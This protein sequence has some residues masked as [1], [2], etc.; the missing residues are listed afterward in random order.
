MIDFYQ[1]LESLD[2]YDIL[3][4]VEYRKPQFKTFNLVLSTLARIIEQK[5]RVFF[6]GDYDVDGLMCALILSEG[7]KHLGLEHYDIFKYRSRTHSLDRGAVHECLQGNYDCFIIGDTGFSASDVESLKMLSRAGI[8]VV[9]LDHHETSFSY[10]DLPD[11]VIG[12]NTT[13]ETESAPDAS[14][15]S[16]GALCFVVM[17]ALAGYMGKKFYEPLSAYATISLYADCMDMRSTLNRAI[18][19]RARKVSREDLPRKVKMFMNSYSSFNSRFIGFWFSPRVNAVFRSEN[20]QLLNTLFLQRS[21][22][23]TT[24]SR[25]LEAVT[26]VYESARALVD[27]VVDIVSVEE[28]QH[29]VLVDLNNVDR[30]I[31]ILENKLYNYTGLIANQLC[32]MYD[33]TAVVICPKGLEF[34]G[35]VRDMYGRCYL[36]IFQKICKAGGHNPAFGFTISIL[37]KQSFLDAV[38]RIDRMFAIEKIAN[39]PVIIDYEYNS[40]DAA[41]IEDIARYNEFAG[42][43]IP[44]VL[45]RK[46][47]I[48]GIRHTIGYYYES[49]DWEGYT[50]QSKRKLDFGS[51]VYLK[52]YKSGRTKLLVQ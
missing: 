45:L 44:M 1:K 12:I 26:K 8:E 37:G 35:S 17:D 51:Y 20:L 4:E 48:G 52:P 38:S 27:K 25:T 42:T 36:P 3:F 14:D 31:N 19:F 28:M 46:Q 13:L 40:I 6:Y 50:I 49:Y 29:F 9:V 43:T 11:G 7:M 41:L 18:Y 5:K 30:Y 32:N 24:E 33:K 21:I 15:L 39:E 34:K 23:A 10:E 47:I 16:A 2:L 22:L